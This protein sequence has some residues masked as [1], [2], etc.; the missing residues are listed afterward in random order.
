MKIY[1]I[2]L[3]LLLA[4]AYNTHAMLKIKNLKI[5]Q[6]VKQLYKPV[7]NKFLFKR[8]YSKIEENAFDRLFKNCTTEAQLDK[9][10]KDMESR[11]FIFNITHSALVDRYIELIEN[12]LKQKKLEQQKNNNLEAIGALENRLLRAKTIDSAIADRYNKSINDLRKSYDRALKNIKELDTIDEKKCAETLQ[13][14][15]DTLA[16]CCN[17]GASLLSKDGNKPAGMFYCCD[18]CQSK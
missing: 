8:F 10:R 15:F 4:F 1:S 17:C 6:C 11:I 18:S 9:H 14:Y 5:M 12:S 2:P 16:I 3:C 13:E 7:I